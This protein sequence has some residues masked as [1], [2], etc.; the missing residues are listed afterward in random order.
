MI[1]TFI[2]RLFGKRPQEPKEEKKVIYCFCGRII[3]FDYVTEQWIH[4]KKG[5]YCHTAKP[6]QE[7]ISD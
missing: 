3:K 2:E 1:I 4:I 5:Y 7:C 6:V